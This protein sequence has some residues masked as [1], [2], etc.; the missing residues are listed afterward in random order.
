[1]VK[2]TQPHSR[3]AQPHLALSGGFQDRGG[4]A[5]ELA[6]GGDSGFAVLGFFQRARH[7]S[8]A[9]KVLDS[10]KDNLRYEQHI[11]LPHFL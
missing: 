6:G 8:R 9:A 10:L 11:N 7:T 3:L 4:S 1:M 5:P 2:V